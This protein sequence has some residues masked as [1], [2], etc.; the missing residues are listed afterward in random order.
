[1]GR[2]VIKV[3]QQ[4]IVRIAQMKVM[5][6]IQS[7]IPLNSCLYSVMTFKETEI[8]T[9]LLGLGLK[10]EIAILIILFLL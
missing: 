3:N 2:K 8:I 1:M 5:N 9:I 6:T 10:K 4:F 7:Y